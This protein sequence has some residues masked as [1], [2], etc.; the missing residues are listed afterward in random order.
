VKHL[1]GRRLVFT[2]VVNPGLMLVFSGICLVGFINFAFATCKKI[3]QGNEEEAPG[4]KQEPRH[5]R[6]TREDRE[7]SLGSL[8]NF[9]EDAFGNCFL[10]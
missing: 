1:L 7:I 4:V 9:I 10:Y 6:Y 3:S 8:G 5:V 2:F